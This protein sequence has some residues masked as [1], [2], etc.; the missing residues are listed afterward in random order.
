MNVRKELSE[1]VGYIFCELASGLWGNGT[2][3]WSRILRIKSD[4]VAWTIARPLYYT[5]NWF[6]NRGY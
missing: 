1:I 2:K 3:I 6:Y 5:G 4:K